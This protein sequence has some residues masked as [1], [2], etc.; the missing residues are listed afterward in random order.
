MY[1]RANIFIGLFTG[2]IT[3]GIISLFFYFYDNIKGARL[4]KWELVVELGLIRKSIHRYCDYNEKEWIEDLFVKSGNKLNR[5]FDKYMRFLNKDLKVLIKHALRRISISKRTYLNIRILN[6]SIKNSEKRINEI[7]E[8]TYLKP[9]NRQKF[10]K[11]EDFKIVECKKKI[12]CRKKR[13]K[14]YKDKIDE[15]SHRIYCCK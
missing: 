12:E 3:G 14:K 8:T 11:D 7:N 9:E 6:D 2:T 5:D 13:L 4:F 10:I 15:L 1:Q